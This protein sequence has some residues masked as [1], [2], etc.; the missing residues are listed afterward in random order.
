MIL[1]E[2]RLFSPEPR[3][4]SAALELYHQVRDLPIY[5]PHGHVSPALF[6]D[7]HARFGNPA[8]LMIQPDHYV[9]RMLWSQG[10]SYADLLGNV[11]PRGV[12]ELF[13]AN[14]YLFNGTPS[15]LWLSH[16]LQEVFGV[17]EKPSAANAAALY[18]QIQAVIDQP[19]FTPRRLYERFGV[20]ALSTT[21]GAEDSLSHHQ[22][23]RDSGWQGRI[24][25]TFRPD[26]VTTLDFPGWRPALTELEKVSGLSIGS[27]PVFIQ[28]LEQQRAR[29]KALGATATDT[30]PAHPLTAQLS[31]SEASA[32]FQRA[33]NG[34]PDSSDAMRFSAH[35]LMEMARM[36]VED[37]LVMQ[38]HPGSYRSH[39]PEVTEL[40]GPNLGFDIP[41]Q[42]EYTRAL[43]PLLAR[44]GNAPGFILILFTLDE[45]TYS[46]EL[47]PLAGAYRAVRLG[48]PWWFHD[49]W[50][51]MTRYFDQV[52]ETAGTWN[53]VGFN[54]D[55]RAFL[56]IPARHDVW[57]R[58][59]AN[60]LAGLQ[61]RGLIDR[62][63]AETM[64]SE[65]A[66]G[67]VRKGYRL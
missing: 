33:L 1:P 26:A 13:C 36:S 15:G 17:T 14:F 18:D 51:G 7:P 22:A 44:F 4:K 32:I 58:A 25:P 11:D 62:S 38:I 5:S 27:Y 42:V 59:A 31:L 23:I 53:T 8:E 43:Q 50:N 30:G 67:L 3:Q 28:A 48:P 52:M 54:D 45:T 57:R 2:D 66:V 47:A 55:T 37:G 21:D 24:L 61:V 49:S 35:M 40:Y 46:R 19:D 64:A 34:A 6:S 63:D 12:W 56:S 10:I 41:F 39:S 20:A 9:L 60:W 29:F 65:M 16:A